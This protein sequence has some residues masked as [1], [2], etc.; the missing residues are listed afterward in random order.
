MCLDWIDIKDAV[1]ISRNYYSKSLHFCQLIFTQHRGSDKDAFGNIFFIDH[2]LYLN[3]LLHV[4][5]YYRNAFILS[6]IPWYVKFSRCK[7]SEVDCIFHSS[8]LDSLDI[9]D[10]ELIIYLS[11]NRYLKKKTF[12]IQSV[13]M[14]L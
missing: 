4:L 11:K 2:A 9:M 3:N 6:K 12:V 5:W 10:T 7:I 13:N 14:I 8:Y 1:L